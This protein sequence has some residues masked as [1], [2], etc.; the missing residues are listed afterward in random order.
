MPARSPA[1]TPHAL[2]YRMP[3][4]WEPHE[5]TWLAW[6]H[7]PEDW[8]GK[9]QSIPWLY[10]EI[11]RLLAA[12][13]RVHLIVENAAAKRARH[14]HACPRRRQSR[15]GQ[16]STPGPPTVAGRAT[17]VRSSS[18]TPRAASPSPTGASM[19]GPSTLTGI[20][21][22]SCLAA[23]RNAGLAG[24]GSRRS[25]ARTVG[26]RRVVL[27]GG[28]IDVNGAGHSAH[29]RRMPSERSATA[30]PRRQPRAT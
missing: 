8:P 20:S 21:T 1:K 4:E 9:F 17:R 27:E 29:H 7:N 3:A 6:P 18:A 19:A 25:R 12:R 14:L 13:E 2:G 23:C 5:A 24:S 28:S 30:Q 10:A 16:L 11:V 22:T 26:S 15:S